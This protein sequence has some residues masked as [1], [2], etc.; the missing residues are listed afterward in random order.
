[1]R[2]V[3]LPLKIALRYLTA[4]KSHRAV[5]AI[6]IISVVGVAVAT[7]AIIIVLSVF[8]GFWHNLNLRLDNLIADIRVMPSYGKTIANGDS[9]SEKLEMFPEIELAMP[10]VSDNALAIAG[11][12][13]M[14]V[15][16]K[17]VNIPK[18]SQITSIDSILLDPGL[19]ADYSG[20]DASISV[21]V[22]NRLGVY[23]PGE[24]ILVF[25]PRREGKVNLANPAASFLTD[26]IFVKS[27]FQSLQ[28]E[29][30]ENTIICDITVARDL[31]LYDDEATSIE[32][33]AAPGAELTRL[34]NN[35]RKQLGS[36]FIVKDRLEQQQIN[37]RMVAVEKWITFLLLTFILVIASFNLISTLSMLVVE[38]EISLVTLSRLGLSVKKIGNIFQWESLLV[39]LTGGIIGLIIG[40]LLS[41][42]QEHFG[43]IKLAGDPEMLTIHAYPVRVEWMDILITSVP[44]I[45]IGLVTC[46]ISYYFA[47]NRARTSY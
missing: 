46:R 41:L 33:K 25:A 39:T 1:M 47:K 5:S 31:F 15:R 34:A 11:Q 17:G 21:G 6:S 38:K 18:Y 45:V 8:N 16:L 22:A 9:L 10:V 36:D 30:D 27:I 2:G 28:S 3:S 26:S 40:I 23:T 44:V 12:K 35:L 20:N 24:N 32:L 29:T 43:F 42:L 19:F 4:P 7:A 14:P 13:E 37:F